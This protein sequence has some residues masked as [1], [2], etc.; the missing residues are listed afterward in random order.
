MPQKIK[1]RY[2]PHLLDKR[3]HFISNHVLICEFNN[4]VLKHKWADPN[5][6]G[7]NSSGSPHW[8]QQYGPAGGIN[9]TDPFRGKLQLFWKVQ[10]GPNN[11]S[12]LKGFL[13]SDG[14]NSEDVAF[15]L[16]NQIQN[17]IAKRGPGSNMPVDLY[18]PG[19]GGSFYTNE[20]PYNYKL[21]ET[22]DFS[23]NTKSGLE[24]YV[25]NSNKGLMAL[26]MT[27]FLDAQLSISNYNN[28]G[29]NYP[30][31]EA[32]IPN[33]PSP[34]VINLNG[35]VALDQEDES[36]EKL[37]FNSIFKR[38]LNPLAHTNQYSG[39]DILNAGN[40]IKVNGTPDLNKHLRAL[41]VFSDS[42]FSL[43]HFVSNQAIEI[44]DSLKGVGNFTGV[45]FADFDPIYN[46]LSTKY[47]SQ[48]AANNIANTRIPN[49]YNEIKKLNETGND[50]SVS[51]DEYL[52]GILT[53][54]SQ[55]LYWAN[56]F[57]K[58]KE[59]G[60]HPAT[61]NNN[62]NHVFIE[63]EGDYSNQVI[64]QYKETFPMYV[65]ISFKSHS[66]QQ[67]I[68][69][70]LKSSGASRDL[71]KSIVRHLFG[72]YE[73]KEDGSIDYK[74]KR[75]IGEKYEYSPYSAGLVV[76]ER[77]SI[78]EYRYKA[79]IEETAIVSTKNLNSLD[80]FELEDPGSPLQGP[81]RL[82]VFNFDKWLKN[83]P[84]DIDDEYPQ[85]SD[86]QKI[87]S[88]DLNSSEFLANN[89]G[90][91][92][93][94]TLSKNPLVILFSGISQKA[95]LQPAV[96][97]L[98]ST[99]VRSYRDI[100]EGKKAYS[101]VLFYRIQKQLGNNTLQN[102]WLENTPSVDVLK[103]IDTQVKYGVDYDYR[104]YAYTAVVGTKYRYA[105]NEIS[106]IS[107][108]KIPS[109]LDF[110]QN[111]GDFKY[112]T[113]DETFT[114]GAPTV[115]LIKYLTD[116]E[117]NP[118]GISPGQGLD[119][120]DY[121]E[122][123]FTPYGNP[124][125]VEPVFG[126]SS[127]ALEL[128]RDYA[129]KYPQIFNPLLE[130]YQQ[131]QIEAGNLAEDIENIQQYKAK[132][133]D[134]ESDLIAVATQVSDLNFGPLINSYRNSYDIFFNQLF[135]DQTLT[136]ATAAGWK[137]DLNKYYDG[138]S[139][140]ILTSALDKLIFLY[141]DINGVGKI[142]DI[143]VDIETLIQKYNLQ[144]QVFNDFYN[145]GVNS[146]KGVEAGKFTVIDE[147]NPNGTSITLESVSLPRQAQVDKLNEI[148]IV[149][150]TI[151][152]ALQEENLVE[153]GLVNNFIE[154]QNMALTSKETQLDNLLGE[155][156][157]R[158]NNYF[159]VL[160]REVKKK[161]L[162]VF[163]AA[164]KSLKKARL[165][166]VSE[167]Y[168]K[169]VETPV[170]EELASVVDDPPLAPDVKFHSYY[171]NDSTILITFD[172]TIGTQRAEQVLFF[173]DDLEAAEKVRRKQDKD[174]TYAETEFK[175][176]KKSSNYVDPKITFKADDY[177]SFFQVF[178]KTTLPKNK[179]DFGVNDHI[180]SVD[181]SKSASF[182]DGIAPNTKY[183]YTFRTIDKHGHPSNPSPVY[184][185]ELVSDAGMIY[186]LIDAL[187]FSET[188][189]GSTFKSFKRFLQIDPAF[190]QTLVNQEKT[191]FGDMTTAF[192]VTPELGVLEESVFDEKRKF[193]IR[194]TSRATGKKLDFNVEFSK[195]LDEI[196][197]IPPT[198]L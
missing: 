174:Y 115:D 125:S 198:I 80:P 31:F 120:L 154:I 184:E 157:N 131:A 126:W 192:G 100:L 16:P 50:N 111:S 112:L 83:Y 23:V 26:L 161:N 138:S 88:L 148:K 69:N 149:L 195:S 143:L 110:D 39:N 151:L 25:E 142:Q 22:V 179:L 106:N 94:D 47:E 175:E 53:G 68:M 124:Q 32:Y 59:A 74:I 20:N 62:F 180:T 105:V 97:Q 108:D 163:A 85:I 34:L 196:T 73:T 187:D 114:N 99:L 177:A 119:G 146:G 46:F 158:L 91:S 76:D 37:F 41:G 48:L 130:L 185:I 178:R 160:K 165:Q 1:I 28:D 9:T 159:E 33:H 40:G 102:F 128:I 140:G 107:N 19:L 109:I 153:T 24:L 118:I 134:F 194:I 186:L 183:Y 181:A 90:N 87:E 30:Y 93:I 104:I 43:P 197:K 14:D 182:I 84:E 75:F 162:Y 169:I 12:E 164:D 60:I 116:I 103:Y 78:R 49:I 63:P 51:Y 7:K 44:V 58:L 191:D 171:K 189:K 65:D 172:N 193:K 155:D 38:L 72:A 176:S 190:L 137:M 81:N 52:E 167:P 168:I 54:D 56:Y 67:K 92:S 132:L 135:D 70:A 4:V 129:L 77:A 66:S 18:Y 64:D 95:E 6:S 166:V 145:A 42:T 82:P 150:S 8:I 127:S 170:F 21:I 133:E 121:N 15:E 117:A 13:F 3:N 98:A 144:I 17:G 61:V 188:N 55:V 79:G 139:F 36:T 101:E 147:L 5:Y 45:H 29:G 11:H 2:Q 113:Y 141:Q 57:D 156:Q 122:A 173:G 136:G 123:I 71:W 89:S 96:K 35:T 27:C 86:S 10:G 152:K